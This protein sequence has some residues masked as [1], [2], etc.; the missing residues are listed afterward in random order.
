MGDR[1][2]IAGGCSY[3]D[4]NFRTN[5]EDFKMP[6][7]TWPMWPEHL[8]KKLNLKHVNVGRCGY[9]NF[10]IFETVLKAIILNED[11]V[12]T[13]VVLWSGWDRSIL[14]NVLPIVTLHAFYNN[15]NKEEVWALPGWMRESKFDET[16]KN[17]LN[18]DWWDPPSF[19][20]DSVNN[21]LSLMYALATICESKNIKY[22]FYQGIEPIATGYI[23]SIENKIERPSKRKFEVNDL[24]ILKQ[25][26]KCPFSGRL[27][28]RKKN[29]IG[30]PFLPDA[31]GQFLDKIRY[32][33]KFFKKGPMNLSRIDRHPNAE[34]QHMIADIFYDQWKKVYD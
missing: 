23:N 25:M 27:E 32:D 28:E 12:D 34:A 22:I 10:T 3:T 11:K 7:K 14:F 30:W 15:L 26:K 21:T 16:I 33:F 20:R 6:E 31:G 18:S 13:V 1:I 9:D 17:Y 29:I 2:L 19:I 5:A 8:A 24:D 4:E